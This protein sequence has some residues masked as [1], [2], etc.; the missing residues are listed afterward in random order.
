MYMYAFLKEFCK[1]F[2]SDMWLWLGNFA[3]DIG[4]VSICLITFKNLQ[5]GNELFHSVMSIVTALISA[6]LIHRFK[7]F[8]TKKKKRKHNG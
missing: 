1:N 7:E 5:V 4:G 6:Y 3:E 2:F 8:L